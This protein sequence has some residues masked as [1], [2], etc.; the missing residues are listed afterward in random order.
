MKK[1]PEVG[2]YFLGWNANYTKTH[3][4]YFTLEFGELLAHQACL[5]N[6]PCEVKVGSCG[7]HYIT[8]M[9]PEHASYF[10]EQCNELTC[11]TC[12]RMAQGEPQGILL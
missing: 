11:P 1:L 10:D 5:P 12:L 2:R 4:F 8:G 6:I 7:N 9:T 3:I